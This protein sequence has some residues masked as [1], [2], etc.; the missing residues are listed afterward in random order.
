MKIKFG[1]TTYESDTL[2]QNKKFLVW[3]LFVYIFEMGLNILSFPLCC[4]IWLLSFLVHG[5]WDI[6]EDAADWIRDF[7]S[8]EFK[9][10]IFFKLLFKKNG[11]NE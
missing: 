2:L 5:G 10:K 4:I 8:I 1:K 6:R 11:G 3:M 9:W 7:P